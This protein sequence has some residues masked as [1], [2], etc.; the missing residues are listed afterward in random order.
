MVRDIIEKHNGI[1]ILRLDKRETLGVYGD[2]ARIAYHMSLGQNGIVTCG[3]RDSVQVTAFAKVCDV[4]NTP[5]YVHIPKG[6]VT[7]SIQQLEET[8]CKIIR[9]KVGHN[10]VLNA[11]ARDNAKEMG[12][13]F[14]Q[15][16]MLCEEAYQ[17]IGENA[18]LII[19]YINKIKRIVIPVGS[20]TTMIG[21][22]NAL[23][24]HKINVPVLGVMTG[25]DAT[26]NIKKDVR[27]DNYKLVK[28]KESYHEK[29]DSVFCGIKL[30]PTYE[31]KCAPYLQV[32][33]LFYIVSK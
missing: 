3:S 28:S 21:M 12:Y 18:K 15:L 22:C 32:G 6:K 27:Y 2:K 33:D 24:Q 1:Y 4:L 10:N 11:H 20:G 5:C 25:M 13:K 30:N 23:A 14:V 26:K 7:N 8:N 19:P 31:A 16:G 29:S 17:L 9:E